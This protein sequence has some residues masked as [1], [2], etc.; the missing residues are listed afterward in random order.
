MLWSCAC[1]RHYEPPLVEMLCRAL[2]SGAPQALQAQ[3]LT[4]LMW[5]VAALGAGLFREVGPGVTGVVV[6]IS[7]G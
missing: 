2:P 3:D 1:L 7:V 4:Q 5:A 6:G